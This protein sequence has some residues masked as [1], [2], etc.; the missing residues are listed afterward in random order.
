MAENKIKLAPE[1]CSYTDEKHEKLTL[2]ILIPGVKKEN[3]NLR[4]HDDSFTLSAPRDDI[5]Y[6]TTLAFCCPVKYQAAEAKYENGLLRVT[7]PFKDPMED[8]V[9]IAVS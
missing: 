1:V 7:V 8:A 3:I 2:E 9:K 6:V 4:M 5:E